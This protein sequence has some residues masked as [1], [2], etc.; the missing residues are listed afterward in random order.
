[1][2]YVVRQRSDLTD[3]FKSLIGVMMAGDIVL[4]ILWNIYL[5]DL[6]DVIGPDTDDI[7][8]NGRPMSHL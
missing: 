3:A 5:A 4:F 8:L 1:M 6:A 2:S 7:M